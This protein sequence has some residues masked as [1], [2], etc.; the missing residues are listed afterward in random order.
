MPLDLL[1]PTYNSSK[2]DKSNV[3]THS[4]GFSRGS[5]RETGVQ[6]HVSH[7]SHNCGGQNRCASY[8]PTGT[9]GT[10]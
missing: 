4:H 2:T 10:V 6:T 8:Y 1:T 5:L 3:L 9:C 7:S